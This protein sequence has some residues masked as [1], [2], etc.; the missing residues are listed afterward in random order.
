MFE[1]YL[2]ADG[3]SRVE[4]YPLKINPITLLILGYWF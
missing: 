3:M 4:L 2:Y 1:S